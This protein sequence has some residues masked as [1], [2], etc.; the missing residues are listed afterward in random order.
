MRFDKAS[1]RVWAGR[2]RQ[3][4]ARRRPRRCG[5]EGLEGREMMAAS[6]GI[7]NGELRV[8]ADPGGDSVKVSEYV[9]LVAPRKFEARVSVESMG[10]TSGASWVFAK[11]KV[12]KIVFDGG[13]ANDKFE[14]FTNLA[15]VAKGNGGDDVLRG[16][17]GA[18]YLDG[19][20]GSD[21]LF[22]GGGND[23]LIGGYGN[24]K[25]YGES[26]NDSLYGG[27]DNDSMYGGDGDDYLDAYHGNDFLDGE[28][29]N[30]TLYGG[31]HDDTLIGGYGNDKLYGQWGNDKLYGGCDDDY[32]DGDDGNDYL[33]AY[34]G[35]DALRGGAGMDAM[36]GGAGNDSLLLNTDNSL[37]VAYGQWGADR[38]LYQTGVVV[39]GDL[40]DQGAEDVR[41]NFENGKQTSVRFSN[42]R[43]AGVYAAGQ[44][45]LQDVDWV[46]AAFAEVVRRT[47]NNSLVK[48]SSGAEM[49]FIRYGNT[50]SG[51][52]GIAGWNGGGR[53]SINQFGFS[54]GRNSILETVFHEIGHNWDEEY[55]A[56]A[57]RALSGWTNKDPKSSKYA[58]GTNPNQSWWYLKSAAFSSANGFYSHSDPNEDFAESFAAYF[59]QRAGQTSTANTIPNKITFIDNMCTSKTTA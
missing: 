22:G 45:T 23:T 59:L 55:D 33:D 25:L 13:K 58:K 14:N 6:V 34:S 56:S 16:G 21:T 12:K 17:S 27:S 28:L 46:D 50:I 44:W 3:G 30:D 48:T 42:Q 54:L 36:Y 49:T 57:W 19:V 41:I 2:K 38:F 31:A 20:V 24:D 32:L 18:D 43:K 52:S 15:C 8:T 1:K 5:F 10:P 51:P 26:G 40:S 9:M 4:R 7:V 29:G 37:D 53:I 39:P 11:T 35:N 47:N